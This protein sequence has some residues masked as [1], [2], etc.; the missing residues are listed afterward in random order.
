MCSGSRTRCRTGAPRSSGKCR[1]AWQSGKFENKST[2]P[3]PLR[4]RQGNIH[5]G[6]ASGKGF[7]FGKAISNSLPSEPAGEHGRGIEL[8]RVATD[9]VSFER[10]STEVQKANSVRS[11]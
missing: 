4:T 2:H 7:D 11:S 5:R 6:D 8:M 9:K 1:R 3:L 10:A